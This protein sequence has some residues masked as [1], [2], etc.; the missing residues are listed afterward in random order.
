[1]IEVIN[2][3]DPPPRRPLLDRQALATFLAGVLLLLISFTTNYTHGELQHF[4]SLAINEQVGMGLHLAVLAA[5]FG[6][7]ELA[8]RLRHRAERAREQEANEA[9]RERDRADEVREQATRRARVANGCFVAQ[10]RFLLS[11][12]SRKRL[13]LSEALAVLLEQ[14]SPPANRD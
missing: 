5:L 7:V 11:G 1:L 14:L 6:D 4:G 12:T 8:T 13:Q 2:D 10:C 3:S 9:A